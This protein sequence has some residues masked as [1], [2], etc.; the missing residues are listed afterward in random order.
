MQTIAIVGLGLI[1]GSLAAALRESHPDWEI[2]G[3]NR[4]SEPLVYAL[5]NDIVTRTTQ[6]IEAGIADADLIFVATPVGMII[7]MIE[8]IA[9]ACK[10]GAIVTDVGSTKAAIV[11]E[12][13]KILGDNAHFV[14]GHPMAGSEKSGVEAARSDLFKNAFYILTPTD[15]TDTEALRKV[16]QIVSGLNA[17]VLALSPGEHD[18]TIAAISHVPHFTSACLVEVA[19]RYISKSKDLMQIAAGGFRDMTRIAAGNPGMWCDIAMANRTA[20]SEGLMEL[21][22]EISQ[23]ARD[24]EAGDAAAITDLLKRAQETR[25]NLPH[26]KAKDIK[27]LYQVSIDVTDRPG[28]LSDVT[29]EVGKLG[30]NI[31]NIEIIHSTEKMTG[32]LLLL[33]I[34][35]ESATRAR[36][37]L[38][39]RGYDVTVS[40]AYG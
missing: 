28:V 9:K 12:A 34:G 8:R 23:T 37:A 39:D 15:K 33:I 31:E 17:Y 14:G 38:Q 1:G 26:V 11:F 10:P 7:P 24:I 18:R 21:A 3:I 20:I 19:Q 27:E 32:T 25:L 4:S 30:V 13:E 6:S 40:R 2:V 29:V 22:S 36:D 16:H 35:E 5:N